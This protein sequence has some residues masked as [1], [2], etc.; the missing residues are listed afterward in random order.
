MYLI[1]DLRYQLKTVYLQLQIVQVNF[2]THVLTNIHKHTNISN[3][4]RI[5][6]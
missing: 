4:I 5:S 6:L 3:T 1:A 2:Q